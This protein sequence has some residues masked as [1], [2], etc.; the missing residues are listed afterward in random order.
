GRTH[1]ARLDGLRDFGRGGKCVHE[2]RLLLHLCATYRPSPMTTFGLTLANRGVV[3]GITTASE[4]IDLAVAAEQ[5]G[6]FHSVYVGDSL[7]GNP[8]LESVALLSA[9]AARTQ[10][11]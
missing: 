1:L 5:T 9:I 3:F 10:R 4:L 11:V 7:L 2:R 6:L 8:R